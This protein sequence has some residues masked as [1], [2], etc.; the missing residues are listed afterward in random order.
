MPTYTVDWTSHHTEAW[1]K[2][3]SAF[4]G[5]QS[6]GL[7]IGVNEGRSTDWFCKNIL[8]HDHS[9]LIC[10]DPFRNKEKYGVFLK[11]AIENDLLHKLDI[12]RQPSE[13]MAIPCNM[14]DFAYI[15]GWHEAATVLSD[16]MLCWRSLKK[17][18]VLI[19][20]DYLWPGKGQV[21]YIPPK[22]A[23]DSFLTIFKGKYQLLEQSH[24]VI[25]RKL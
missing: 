11:N 1:A 20:D 3:L 15:D 8:T 2:H 7:E 16:S 22:P 23:I 6:I 25:V 24:E 10:V 14:L 18:G 12:R 17:G 4:N 9:R 5:R 19:W 13:Q 21:P